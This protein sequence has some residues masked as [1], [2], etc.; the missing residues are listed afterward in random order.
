LRL[1]DLKTWTAA[2]H[3]SP[4]Q[5]PGANPRSPLPSGTNFS[6]S[7]FSRSV[8]AFS[9][10]PKARRGW[11][12]A[13]LEGERCATLLSMRVPDVYSLGEGVNRPRGR[14]VVQCADWR[15][16][17]GRGITAIANWLSVP[18]RCPH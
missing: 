10:R 18:V 3:S 16:G 15:R 9:A 17:F 14:A 7:R 8:R 6:P 11:R 2:R 12:A 1:A 5:P 4:L 13:T